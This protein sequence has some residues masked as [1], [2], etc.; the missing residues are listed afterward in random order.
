MDILVIGGSGHVSGAVARAAQAASHRVWTV[1]RGKRPM[2]PGVNPIVVDRRDELAMASAISGAGVTWDLVVDCICY[3]VPDIRQDIAL[4]RERAR[5]FVLIS[6]DFVYD[7]AERTFPQAEEADVWAHKAGQ[8]YGRRKRQCEV[9]LMSA[10]TGG[11]GWTILR[12]C[13]IYGATSELGCLPMHGRDPELVRRL[14]AGEPLKLVGGG[15]FL[16]QPI[17]ADDLARTIV[18]VV[19]NP[20]AAR[21][22]FNAAGPDIVES[23]RYYEIVAEALGAKLAVDEVRVRDCLADHPEMEPFLCHRIYDLS[24]LAASGLHRPSTPIETGLL[25]HLDGL[26]ARKGLPSR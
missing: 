17:L 20:S 7:P 25:A 11:M 10:D 3:D 5:Q 14:R 6:T 2:A 19:G 12:P 4:F 22:V 18:S 8:D 16:Q 21:R 9:E 15:H 23:R 26:L 1:T 24:R 13:H